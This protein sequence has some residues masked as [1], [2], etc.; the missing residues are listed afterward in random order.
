M[1]TTWSEET[2]YGDHVLIPVRVSEGWQVVVKARDRSLITVVGPLPSKE[3]A[4]ANAKAVVNSLRAQ[5]R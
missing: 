4:L 5:E 2:S 3:A 1:P